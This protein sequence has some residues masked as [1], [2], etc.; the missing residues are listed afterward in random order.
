MDVWR[1]WERERVGWI[2]RSTDIYTPPRANSIDSGELLRNTGS[3]A[4]GSDD[5]QEWHGRAAQK[6]DMH[7]ADSRCCCTAETNTTL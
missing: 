4:Q 2:E 6:K 5:L 7:M 1:Q 3:T